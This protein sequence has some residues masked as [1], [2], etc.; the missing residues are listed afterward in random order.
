MALT[1]VT[2]AMIEGAIVNA[3]DFGAVGDGVTDDT[4]AIQAAIDYCLTTDLDPSGRPTKNLAIS[5]RCLITDSL[6]INRL[7]DSAAA[8]RYFTIYG[9]EGGGLVTNTDSCVFFSTTLSY[10]SA[11][12]SQMIRFE[13]LYF[14]STDA[15]KAT[16]FVLDGNKFLRTVF[17][18]CNFVKTRCLATSGAAYT[19]S[20]Y[21]FQCDMRRVPGVF[22]D[23]AAPT[24]DLKVMG[25]LMEATGS[26]WN[27]VSAGCAF[28]GNC[29][30]GMSAGYTIQAEGN[31]LTVSGNYFEGSDVDLDFSGG[32]NL[33]FSITGNY[34]GGQTGSRYAIEW[35]NA[36]NCQSSGNYA[37][38]KLHNFT[39]T[40]RNVAI[41]DYSLVEQ[42]NATN[43]T[44]IYGHLVL[45][46]PRGY[47]SSTLFQSLNRRKYTGQML[48]SVSVTTDV[49]EID[50]NSQY[51]T[52]IIDMVV[53]GQKPGVDYVSQMN[54]WVATQ[55]AGGI[56][57]T[58]A[59]SYNE[60]AAPVTATVSGGN[61]IIAWTYGGSGANFFQM[62]YEVLGVAGANTQSYISVTPL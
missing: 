47:G 28:V 26:G 56:T 43:T 30:E 55:D 16:T 59:Q 38:E 39:T 9:F 33:G 23:C 58:A 45:E 3:V 62:A 29:M 11:P 61:I 53:V 49:L 40:N 41:N 34:F 50:F 17:Q 51:G 37:V 4:A 32:D 52:V 8:D 48:K 7:V 44:P 6:N 20:I 31:G 25:C 13:N 36:Y 54:R 1:K 22:F 21:F 24:Y 57:L 5:G 2:Y 46:D 10:T 60:G 18:G 12:V 27:I 15:V 19:Q 42:A 14:E 35:G